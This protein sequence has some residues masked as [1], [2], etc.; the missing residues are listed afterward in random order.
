MAIIAEDMQLKAFDERDPLTGVSSDKA[1]TM[2]ERTLEKYESSE[3]MPPMNAV[4]KGHRICKETEE[5]DT[6]TKIERFFTRTFRKD[7]SSF[8]LK[9]PHV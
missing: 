4:I 9:K 8:S 7:Q 5:N 6:T 1:R 3:A 2:N